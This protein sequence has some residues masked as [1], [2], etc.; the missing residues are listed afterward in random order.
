MTARPSLRLALLIPVSLA[1]TVLAACGPSGSGT[2]ATNGGTTGGG[3]SQPA[4]SPSQPV[5]GGSSS[6]SGK[7]TDLT[8][9]G[10]S[11]AV[12]KPTT[13]TLDPTVAALP[14]LTICTVTV[15]DEVYP[16]QLAV[17]NNGG[18]E[19]YNADKQVSAGTDLSG[20]GDKAFTDEIGV[21]ALSGN[22]DIKVTG[23][24]GPV[25][26]GNFAVPTAIAKA[27]VTALQ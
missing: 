5:S 2:P 20:V 3:T 10:A 21:E 23:P 13:V 18:Q 8:A 7:C 9:A 15:A 6:G 16:I 12:G 17:D 11:A 27:M 24:A 14:G 4:S 25:L 26:S 19:L 22:V 1:A